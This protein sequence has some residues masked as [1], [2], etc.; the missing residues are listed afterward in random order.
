MDNDYQLELS[1]IKYLDFLNSPNGQTQKKVL[2]DAILK[3]LPKNPRSAILDAGCGPGWLAANLKKHCQSVE[4]CDSSD[5]LIKVAKVEFPNINFQVADLNK[6]LPYLKNFFDCVILNMVAPDLGAPDG[7]FKNLCAV[8]KP[9]GKLII[10]IPNPRLTY[11]AAVWK[12]GVLGFILRQKPQLKIKNPPLEGK[13]IQ[14]E[15]GENIKIG[16][17]YH[18]LPYYIQTAKNAGLKLKQQ[19]EIK[20]QTDSPNFDLTYQLYRYPLILL[21][22]F[23]KRT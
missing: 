12:R 6:P 7:A 14:R 11:P 9:D 22:E 4:A 10:T 13:K 16:S 2:A 18:S 19:Q 20:S 21:L 5:F 1:A 3:V 17:Y 23:E 15:F 8:L